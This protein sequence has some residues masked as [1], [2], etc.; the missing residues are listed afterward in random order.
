V[1]PGLKYQAL[2]DDDAQVVLAFGTDGQVSGY[3]LVLLQDDKGLWP[4]YNVAPVVRQD[5]L[6]AYP[7]IADRFNAVTTGLT[8]E[9]LSGL[10][11]QVDGDDKKDPAEVA[12]TYLTDNGFIGA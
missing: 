2:L 8:D 3:D 1:A 4:P 9:I 6:D 10:N 5:V 12:K 11:W 7:D